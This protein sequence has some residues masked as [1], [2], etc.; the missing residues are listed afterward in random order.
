MNG[1]TVGDQKYSFIWDSLLQE[2]EF[3]VDLRTKSTLR[4]PTFN[5]TVRRTAK[6]LVPLM[7]KV[8]V[9][10]GMINTECYAVASHLQRSQY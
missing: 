8:C 7:G 4:A 6:M 9:H 1:R 3:T 10:G 2:G 5:I